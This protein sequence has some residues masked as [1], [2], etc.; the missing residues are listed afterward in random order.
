MKKEFII[1]MP[2]CLILLLS[3]SPSLLFFG[4]RSLHAQDSSSESQMQRLGTT[5][6]LD[7]PNDVSLVFTDH[8][9][10]SI[11]EQFIL[12]GN[13]QGTR[14]DIAI[15]NPDYG[16]STPIPTLMSGDNFIIDSS[17]DADIVYSKATVKLVPITSP[18]P[19][20]NMNI[21]DVD[22]EDDISLGTPITIGS[23]TGDTGTFAIPQT[24]NPG[25]YLLYVYYYYP[26]YNL[27]AVYNTAVQLRAA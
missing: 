20:A 16:L 7:P 17:T 3:V 1:F 6:I 19:P 12:L 25:Y 9:N 26:T 5:N 27:T 2:V 21:E 13:N 15:S 22:P 23:Y 11:N 8:N 14:Q 24:A 10:A 18:F 4:D